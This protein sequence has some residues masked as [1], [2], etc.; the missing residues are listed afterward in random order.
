MKHCVTCCHQGGKWKHLFLWEPSPLMMQAKHT[1]HASKCADRHK[2]TLTHTNVL[3]HTN[4]HCQQF[5]HVYRVHLWK[6][7][8]CMSACNSKTEHDREGREW[9]KRVH[10]C[11]NHD[12]MAKCQWI[13]HQHDSYF[14]LTE[15]VHTA[16]QLH[17]LIQWA[18]ELRLHFRASKK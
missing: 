2:R 14:S 17:L 16:T 8:H 1:K 5:Q 9:K 11:Q 13:P 4:A 3:H 18:S 10:G 7:L 12:Q 6:P 15:R